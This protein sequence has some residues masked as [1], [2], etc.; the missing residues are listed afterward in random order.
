[1][2]ATLMQFSLLN[3]NRYRKKC[4]RRGDLVTAVSRLHAGSFRQYD[5]QLRGHS[6]THFMAYAMKPWRALRGGK[7]L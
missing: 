2:Y 5:L 3:D 4:K 7:F 6:W 1:M